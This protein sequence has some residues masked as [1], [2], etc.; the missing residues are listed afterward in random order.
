MSATE[1]RMRKRKLTKK[2][3][4]ACDDLR[5]YWSAFCDAD[6]TPDNFIDRM[7]TAGFVRLRKVCR[8]DLDEAFAAER[9]VEKGG[10]LWE[11]TKSGRA[12]L[13]LA[14]GEKGNG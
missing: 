5:K 13:F 2:Q 8:S 6:P 11:L 3:W 12:S 4:Q 9:G 7:E 14:R 10:L 1:G